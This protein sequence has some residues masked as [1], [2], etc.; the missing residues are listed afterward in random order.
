MAKNNLEIELLTR[1]VAGYSHY[2][3]RVPVI[4]RLYLKNNG[5]LP[6]ENIAVVVES[7]PAVFLPFRTVIEVLPFDST[8]EVDLSPLSLSPYFLSGIEKAERA[9]VTVRAEREGKTLEKKQS[10]L[11]V[12]P[13]GE[14]KPEA[15]Y[16]DLLAGYV[17]P[18]H[19]VVA[20]LRVRAQEI[21]AKW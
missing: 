1:K 7:E 8:V 12:L 5:E 4:S 20:K 19:P 11:T 6:L 15:E 14:W 21:L 10:N 3:N 13:F 18:R 17:K 2:K 16:V 9:V